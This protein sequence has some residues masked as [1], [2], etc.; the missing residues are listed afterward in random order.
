MTCFESYDYA[1]AAAPR[2]RRRPT[3]TSIAMLQNAS[4]VI[5]LRFLQ[6][7]LYMVRFKKTQQFL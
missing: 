2:P 7:T 1:A 4:H 3:T 6:K 5:T